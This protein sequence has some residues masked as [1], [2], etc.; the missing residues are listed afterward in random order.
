MR[1]GCAF[2]VCVSDSVGKKRG[3]RDGDGGEREKEE[4]R[5]KRKNK[6][7]W[8]KACRVLGGYSLVFV[9]VGSR[10]GGWV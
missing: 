3:R 4:T 10:Y 1:F 2:N 5:K 6:S 7:S 9:V 8:R